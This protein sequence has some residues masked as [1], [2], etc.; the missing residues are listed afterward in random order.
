MSKKAITC[1][2]ISC[3]LVTITLGLFAYDSF[4]SFSTY[5]IL[6]SNPESFGEALGAA[7]GIVILFAMTII[8][9]IAILV[10]GGITLPFV[11]SLLKMNG[12]QWYSLLILIFTIIAMVMAIGYVG[13]LPLI[14]QAESA[15][16]A[17]S[18]SSSSAIPNSTALLFF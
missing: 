4:L 5:S 7:F 8:L 10:S 14:S 13:M 3:I 6:Y 1:L 9:G 16:Q 15:S 18:S 17:A 12:K 11:I 2:I